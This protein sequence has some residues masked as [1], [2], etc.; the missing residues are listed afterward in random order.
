MSK[1]LTE[2]QI[3]TAKARSR[4]E[5]GVHWRRLDSEAHLGYRKGNTSWASGVIAEAIYSFCFSSALFPSELLERSSK[6]SAPLARSCPI[7]LSFFASSLAVASRKPSAA[8][9]PAF[10]DFRSSSICGS[11]LIKTLLQEYFLVH[12]TR[13]HQFQSDRLDIVP[14]PLRLSVQPTVP[15]PQ[16]VAAE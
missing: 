2:A 4:L 13:P 7:L 14:S 8:R 1:I 12:A 9:L 3:T 11:F 6:R 5:L 16:A 10:D 15:C